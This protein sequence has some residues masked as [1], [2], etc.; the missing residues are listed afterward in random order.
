MKHFTPDIL[1][2]L[3]HLHAER[4]REL[5]LNEFTIVQ[6]VLA[7]TGTKTFENI[8]HLSFD[9]FSMV[10]S[11]IK[12]INQFSKQKSL[13]KRVLALHRPYSPINYEEK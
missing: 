13:D 2:C 12:I 10:F 7:P 4:E 5:N 3:Q 11:L 8:V 9:V 1:F 6:L